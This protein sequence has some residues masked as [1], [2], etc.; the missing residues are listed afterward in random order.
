MKSVHCQSINL[1]TATNF[2]AFWVYDK[3]VCHSMCLIQ[4]SASANVDEG[5]WDYSVY[6]RDG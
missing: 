5:V 1:V 3:A 4:T 6:P 2:T